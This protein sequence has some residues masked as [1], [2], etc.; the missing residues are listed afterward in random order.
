MTEAEWN[1]CVDPDAMLNFLLAEG[2]QSERKSRLF[3]VGGKD[4]AGALSFSQGNN[5]RPRVSG[6]GGADPTVAF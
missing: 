5:E 4:M 2:K 6:Q 1:V 3:A